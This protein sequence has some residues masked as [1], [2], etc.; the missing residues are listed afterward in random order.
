MAVFVTV[1]TTQFD[2]LVESVTSEQTI[3]VSGTLD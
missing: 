1:G 3:Q 2:R